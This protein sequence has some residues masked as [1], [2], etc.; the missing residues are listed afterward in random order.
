MPNEKDYRMAR[1]TSCNVGG[2]E[3]GVIPVFGETFD[4]VH[5]EV[6]N[7]MSERVDFGWEFTEED[8]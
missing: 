6:W 8:E 3:F 4:E 7:Y 1:I 5:Q 2:C